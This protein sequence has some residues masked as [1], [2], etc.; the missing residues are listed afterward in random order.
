MWHSS[1]S[2]TTEEGV[3]GT[4]VSS[5]CELLLCEKV[6]PS[7][8]FIYSTLPK[9][10]SF[11]AIKIILGFLSKWHNKYKLNQGGKRIIHWELQNTAERN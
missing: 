6:M 3:S 2:W 10:V 11:K 1:V 9:K 8:T 4:E 7:R 5:I